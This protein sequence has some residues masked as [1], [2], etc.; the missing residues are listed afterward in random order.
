M[1]PLSLKEIWP[2]L[3]VFSIDWFTYLQPLVGKI[4]RVDN[5]SSFREDTSQA[6]PGNTLDDQENYAIELALDNVRDKSRFH[7]KRDSAQSA[8]RLKQ[9]VI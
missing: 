7:K 6:A 8:S 3:D 9:N 2:Q 5:S 4:L 1:I